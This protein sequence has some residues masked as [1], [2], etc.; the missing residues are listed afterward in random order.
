M[1]TAWLLFASMSL[2]FAAE[3]DQPAKTYEVITPKEDGIIATGMNA[4]GEIIG[5]EWIEDK[6]HAGLINQVPFHAKGK[7]IT[8]LPIL[9]GYTATF[10]AAVS[11]EGVVV[12]RAS[13]PAPPRVRV[14]MRNQAFIWDAKGGIRGLGV[15]KDDSSS[16][17]CGITRD[18]R[19]ISGFSV[20]DNRMRAC[21]WDRDGESWKGT[22][23]PHAHQLGSNSVVI[24]DNGK[25]VSAVDGVF[26]CLWTRDD[27][28]GEWTREVIGESG[29]LLP[30]GVNNSGVVVGLRH[31]SD[32]GTHA[33]IWNRKD[34]CFEIEAP[35]DYTRNEALAINNEGVVVGMMDGPHGSK[36]LPRA[37][38]YEDGKIRPL[39]EGGPTFVSATAINDQK[40]VT[41]VFEKDEEEGA[42][43]EPEKAKKTP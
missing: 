14:H 28:S 32:G 17:A 20:G 25:F 39:Q 11:D 41:G 33:I 5:F 4:R 23:L 43:D 37:F 7:V 31:S 21:V 1:R 13:K 22:P 9:Q 8:Y 2:G 15:L 10:P 34:G 12:G 24:S 36:I 27:A 38:V 16:L 35:K 6:Q 3:A 40:Q 29:S 19:R 18:G 26:P 30:R 42:H